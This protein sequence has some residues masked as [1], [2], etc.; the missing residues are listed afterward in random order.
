VLPTFTFRGEN[1][2]RQ[3]AVCAAAATV[4]VA[5]AC[6]NSQAGRIEV[7]EAVLKQRAAAALPLGDYI[8]AVAAAAAAAASAADGSSTSLSAFYEQ[9]R[10]FSGW[11]IR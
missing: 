2:K 7:T 6:K 5:T 8:A 11:Q 9:T 4:I 10:D 3:R 1:K